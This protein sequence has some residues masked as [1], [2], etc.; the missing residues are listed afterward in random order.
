MIRQLMLT[1]DGSHTIF[2]PEMGEHYHSVHGAVQESMHIFI[3]YGFHKMQADPLSILEIGFGTGLNAF[4][5]LLASFTNNKHV[6]YE[7]WEPFPITSE[8]S[9]SLNYPDV[10]KT[11]PENFRKL[12]ESPWGIEVPITPLF[13]LK[14]I[15]HDI[16]TFSSNRLYDLVYFDAFGPD[17]QPE[18]WEPQIFKNI[19][20][21]LRKDSRLVTYSAKGQVRRNLREAGFRIEKAPGPPGKREITIAIKM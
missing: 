4:L 2:L 1:E 7:S 16:H 20:G 18:M 12:H 13:M 15:N 21:A 17:Y 5:T 10:L 19:S 3:N 8:E 9:A 14:K 6:T 11:D